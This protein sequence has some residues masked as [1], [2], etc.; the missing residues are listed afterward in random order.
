M[1]TPLKNVYSFQFFDQLADVLQTVLP[2]FYKEEFFSRIFSEEWEKKELKERMRHTAQVLHH[3]LPPAFP[4]GAQVIQ[5]IIRRLQEEQFPVQHV[6][7]MFLPDYVELYGLEEVETSLRAMETTTQFI[8]CEFA[9]RPFLLRYPAKVMAQMQVWS[10]HEHHAV[11]RFASEGCRPRLPW[12]MAL[13]FLKRDP[14]PILPILENLKADTFEFVRRSVANNLND[15]SKDHPALVLQLLSQWKGQSLQTDWVVKHGCRTLL[16]QGHPEALRHF[17]YDGDTHLRLQDFQVLTP[18]VALGKDL[19]FSFVLK[20]TSELPQKVRLEYGV[21]FQKA[22][23]TLSRK[24]FKISERVYAPVEE[25]SITRRQSFKLITTR[26]Y[27]P[28]PHRVSLIVNGQEKE[29]A[30]FTLLP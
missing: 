20:N 10:L 21:Y 28:G 24:V 16:K 29:I 18:E 30:N 2:S 6:E 26:K 8:S 17:G 23:K 15:I 11:R 1:S 27:Y 12:A 9:I 14:S 13:P 7:F 4:E 3:F 25:T 22:N 19:Q 5:H